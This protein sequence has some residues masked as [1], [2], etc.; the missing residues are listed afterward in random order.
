[1]RPTIEQAH[2][3]QPAWSQ[4]SDRSA[5][6]SRWYQAILQNREGLAHLLTVESGKPL[7]ESAGEI[8]YGARYIQFY[9]EELKRPHGTILMDGHR[10]RMVTREPIGVAAMVSGYS[11]A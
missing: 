8:D 7:A 4:R 3:A 5:I 11:Q 2:A 10:R 1:L 6:L 9:A